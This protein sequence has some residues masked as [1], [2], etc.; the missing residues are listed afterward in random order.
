MKKFCILAYLAL[1]ASVSFAQ[2]NIPVDSIKIKARLDS[3]AITKKT[4]MYIS[5]IDSIHHTYWGVLGSLYNETNPKTIYLDSH[6]YKLYMPLTFYRT[7]ID[8]SFMPRWPNFEYQPYSYPIEELL[9]YNKKLF[10]QY[11]DADTLVNK[12]L[13]Y[14]YTHDYTAIKKWDYQ[15]HGLKLFYINRDEIDTKDTHMISL[16]RPDPERLNRIKIKIRKPNF[17]NVSGNGSMQFSQNYISDN[18]YKGGQSANTMLS[19]LQIDANYNDKNKWEWDNRFELKLGFQ[20]AQSD[21]IHKY[22]VNDNML[23]LTS[24]IGLQATKDWYYTLSVE[25]N[26][27]VLNAYKSNISTRQSAFMSPANFIT[28][29]GMDYKKKSNKVDLSVVLAP[30]AFSFKYMKDRDID[31]TAFGI[32]EGRRT[33]TTVGSTMTTNFAWTINSAIN[34]T[35]RLYYFSNYQSTQAE[36]ENTINFVLNRYLSTKIFFHGRFDDSSTKSNDWGYFQFKD[37][38][39]FGINYSW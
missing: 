13:L 21:S 10:T 36:W 28:S 25:F 18:W 8:Q 31:E 27:Q 30:A 26:T 38:L 3:T 34:Y 12:A 39:S 1:I 22:Q 23:R 19:S 6:F 32:S 7:A 37:L 2:R 4:N 16:F 5:Q 24:K 35:T 14:V 20:T 11:S 29:L 17:W 33:L 9:P 15:I